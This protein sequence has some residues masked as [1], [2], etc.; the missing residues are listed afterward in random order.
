[1]NT[2]RAAYAVL[3]IARRL[4]P[5]ATTVDVYNCGGTTRLDVFKAD[6]EQDRT[7]PHFTVRS[8]CA[9]LDD[10]AGTYVALA[11][12]PAPP[13]PSA[14]PSPTPGPSTSPTPTG[15]PGTTSSMAASGPAS[16]NRPSRR[17]TTYSPTGET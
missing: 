13:G 12:G 16:A 14:S 6:T 15:P 5:E 11:F 8:V 1:M 17:L 7:L 2:S 3:D 9:A 4:Y 10:A